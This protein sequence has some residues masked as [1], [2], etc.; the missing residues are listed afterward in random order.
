MFGPPAG[1]DPDELAQ[2]VRELEAS[3]YHAAL[4]AYVDAR[5]AQLLVDD[6]TTADVAMKR[7]G[8]V[9]E[10]QRLIMP[11]FVKSLALA[12]LAKRAEARAGLED[13]RRAHAMPTRDWWSD[14]VVDVYPES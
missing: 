2:L 14:P 6:V 7:R 9:E 11:L 8:Q 10:L 3:G 4:R 1:V 13:I 5:I 12:A